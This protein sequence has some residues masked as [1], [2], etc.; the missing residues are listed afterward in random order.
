VIARG[1]DRW[2]RI[3]AAMFSLLAITAAGCGSLP[4]AVGPVNVSDF[5]R[6]RIELPSTPERRMLAERI[7]L[8]TGGGMSSIVA[9]RSTLTTGSFEIVAIVHD[10]EYSARSVSRLGEN[11][12]LLPLPPDSKAIVN[13]YQSKN[14]GPLDVNFE[15]ADI[16]NADPEIAYRLAAEM[17]AEFESKIGQVADPL[18]ENL[19]PNASFAADDEVRGTPADWFAYVETSSNVLER[20]LR[21]TGTAPGRRPFLATGPIRVEPGRRYRILVRMTV[22]EGGVSM[23]VADYEELRVISD[24]GT[25]TAAD[26]PVER[27]IDFQATDADRAARIRFEPVTQGERADFE[28]SA[29]QMEVLP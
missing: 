26:G 14:S 19:V 3:Q 25:A 24:L 20:R 29:I 2:K 27:R 28:L 23:R 5:P 21:V 9:V 16:T 18:V 11:L 6:G 17:A 15:T 12:T 1:I 8:E 13:V 4:F 22:F 7:P 10:A